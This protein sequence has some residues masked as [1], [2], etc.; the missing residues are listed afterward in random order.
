MF[1]MRK[2]LKIFTVIKGSGRNAI[3]PCFFTQ[4][5]ENYVN[6]LN[7]FMPVSTM[8]KIPPFK[9]YVILDISFKIIGL[10]N[11]GITAIL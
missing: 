1:L 10:L 5:L 11:S 6:P 4:S 7:D 2:I 9:Y 3:T 8:L